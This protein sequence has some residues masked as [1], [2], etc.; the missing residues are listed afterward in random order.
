M[1]GKWKTSRNYTLLIVL[2]L[3]VMLA[4]LLQ[5]K[6]ADAAEQN[7]VLDNPRVTVDNNNTSYLKS[8]GN[9]E[10]TKQ[11]IQNLQSSLYTG[12][13]NLS[14]NQGHS[15]NP[16]IVT[17]GTYVYTLWLDDTAGNRD[18]YFKRSVDNGSTFW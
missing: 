4:I 8:L 17:D 16:E 9:S 2:H 10:S 1:K 3:A 12:T 7:T 5:F 11:D 18:I 6:F 14:M 15:E 13:I